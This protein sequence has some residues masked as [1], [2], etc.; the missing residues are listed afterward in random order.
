MEDLVCYSF[1]VARGMEFLASR[2]VTVP[3]GPSEGRKVQ[4]YQHTKTHTVLAHPTVMLWSGDVSPTLQRRKLTPECESDF[5]RSL[6][7]SSGTGC[8]ICPTP[9]PLLLPPKFH[10]PLESLRGARNLSPRGT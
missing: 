3:A 4:T 8:G 5:P 6:A 2:K 1:Q 9:Q 10:E 7:I